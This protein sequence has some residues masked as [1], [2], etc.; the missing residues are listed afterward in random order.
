M[1]ARKQC[2]GGFAALLCLAV[3]A[4]VLVLPSCASDKPCG[5]G[6]AGATCPTT[7][8]PPPASVKTVVVQ[9]SIA[10]LPVDYVAGRSF[11]TSG[12]GTV[13]VTV[14]WTFAE[15]TI[16][17]WLAK[18]QCTYEQ[19]DADTCQY[20]TQSLTSRPKPRILSMPGAAAGTYT[21]IVGN[22]GP[23]DEAVSYQVVLT[24]ASGAS[25]SVRRLDSNGPAGF[26]GAWRRR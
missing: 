13:D 23:R 2:G 11:S 15:N 22:V 16:Y 24:S 6:P 18:G 9:A 10:S 20:V 21:L 25:T 7:P 3:V 14:D 4:A 5:S 1:N 8:P 12:T 17:V 19:F 26:L